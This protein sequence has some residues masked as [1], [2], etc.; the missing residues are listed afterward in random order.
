MLTCTKCLNEI[1]GDGIIFRGEVY[2]KKCRNTIPQSRC[3]SPIKNSRYKN[4]RCS[5]PAYFDE[6]RCTVHNQIDAPVFEWDKCPYCLPR[7][8]KPVHHEMCGMCAKKDR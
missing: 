6:D 5:N 2:C 8:Q 3:K 1:T 7:R 4:L